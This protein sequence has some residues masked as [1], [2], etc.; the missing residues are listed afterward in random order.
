MAWRVA[1]WILV[2][3]G[4]LAWCAAIGMFASPHLA[5]EGLTIG[6]VGTIPFLVG[7]VIF[8]ARQAGG[9]IALGLGIFLVLLG[10]SIVLASSLETAPIG[11]LGIPLSCFFL[12][13]W[14]LWFFIG[15]KRWRH[16]GLVAHGRPAT[17]VVLAV[18]RVAARAPP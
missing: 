13:G 6:L 11:G 5:H 15:A 16:R 7:M 3:S 8:T 9:V 4:S 18:R 10:G 2:G 14:F 12:F 1:Q 17:A